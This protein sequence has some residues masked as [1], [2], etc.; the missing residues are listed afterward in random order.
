MYIQDFKLTV[1]LISCP[2][3]TFKQCMIT[4]K[5]LDPDIVLYL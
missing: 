1:E 4:K 3:E 5:P 2:S